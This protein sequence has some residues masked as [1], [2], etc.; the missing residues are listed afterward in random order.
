MSK[1]AHWDFSGETLVDKVAGASMAISRSTAT[2]CRNSSGQ[3][4]LVPANEP[5]YHYAYDGT[6]VGLQ[7]F[8]GNNTLRSPDA[9][10]LTNG[11]WF[12]LNA[13]V[14]ANAPVGGVH[15]S[16]AVQGAQFVPC[17]H[18]PKL[19]RLVSAG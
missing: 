6:F 3:L 13:T 8:T 11:S 15:G 10:D 16:F 7:V 12:K 18:I 14:G 9:E 2:S 17:G 19:D 1:Q 5:A 4:E